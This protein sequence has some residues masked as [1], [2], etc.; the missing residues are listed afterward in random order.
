MSGSPAKNVPE[1]NLDEFERRLRTA[2]PTEGGAEDPLVELTRLVN[3]IS[4][5]S[6]RGET[7]AHSGPPVM[8]RA[9]GF[10]QAANDETAPRFE[11][12]PSQPRDPAPRREPPLP[13][14]ASASAQFDHPEDFELTQQERAAL[15][16]EA[17]EV[18]AGRSRSRSWYFKTAGLAAIGAM[19]LAGA[20]A[21][22]IGV[23]PGLPKKPPFIAAAAGPNKIQPPSDATVQS[24]GDT[25]ALLM[26]DSDESDP[27]QSRLHGGAAG[28]SQRADAD[29][30]ARCDRF[31]ARRRE[32]ARAKPA[33]TERPIAECVIPCSAVRRYAGRPAR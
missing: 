25:A 2:S 10:P 4:R 3:M 15:L 28:R 18:G 6:N 9:E 31:A 17:D 7:A 11:A 20:G 32:F 22:K 23:V 19:L 21:L 13:P 5:E 1:I 12:G 27:G 26:K 29:P 8:P 24:G 33:Y 16:A 30:D 14:A